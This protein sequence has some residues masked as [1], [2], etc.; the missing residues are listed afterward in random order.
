MN[1]S[2]RIMVYGLPWRRES[3]FA[4][5][6]RLNVLEASMECVIAHMLEGGLK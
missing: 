6:T 3:V 1:I 2:A 4:G 5:E